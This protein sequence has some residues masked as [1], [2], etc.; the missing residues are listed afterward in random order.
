MNNK[1]I[2]DPENAS[3]LEEFHGVI[4]ICRECA[5]EHRL[6]EGSVLNQILIG[7]DEIVSPLCKE[8]YV[9]ILPWSGRT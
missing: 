9:S 4:P 2:C 8:S 5:A 3:I 7:C 6:P 1:V